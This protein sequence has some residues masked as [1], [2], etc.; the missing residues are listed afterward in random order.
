MDSAPWHNTGRA[1]SNRFLDTYYHAGQIQPERLFLQEI[2]Y[3]LLIAGG[4]RN[5]TG[6]II[7]IGIRAVAS[8]SEC[9]DPILSELPPIIVST[10]FYHY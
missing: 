8:P 2:R 4:S 3:G 1:E 10:R 5:D 6:Q 9:L 7:Y